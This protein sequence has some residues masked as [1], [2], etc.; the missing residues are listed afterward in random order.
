[1]IRRLLNNEEEHD[2]YALLDQMLIEDWDN[3]KDAIY[4]TNIFE[5]KRKLSELTE[6]EMRQ[7]MDFIRRSRKYLDQE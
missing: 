1:M 5:N 7:S 4:D 3:E 6:K 2:Y